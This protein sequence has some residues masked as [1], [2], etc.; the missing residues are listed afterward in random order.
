MSE[1]WKSFPNFQAEQMDP[2]PKMTPYSLWSRQVSVQ[3][4]RNY[5][6]SP[7]LDCITTLQ[8]CSVSTE[9]LN[10]ESVLFNRH[11]NIDFINVQPKHFTQQHI[12]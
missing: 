6:N 9:S 8:M 10:P 12:R 1:A 5:A 11:K 3:R 4:K 7:K 2:A